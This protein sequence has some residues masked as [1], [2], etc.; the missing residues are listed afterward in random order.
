LN[1]LEE[2][3]LSTV[4]AIHPDEEDSPLPETETIEAQPEPQ[5]A[6][7]RMPRTRRT[8][9]EMQAITDPSKRQENEEWLDYLQRIP[10]GDWQDSRMSGLYVYKIGRQGFANM[11]LGPDGK[12]FRKPI[13]IDDLKALAAQHGPGQYKIQLSHR[14][15]HL[16][17]GGC[18]FPFDDV[19]GY[20]SKPN[21][22]QQQTD[23]QGINS[24]ITASSQ[25]LEHSAK[26]AID[27]QK[28]VHVENSKQPD[29]GAML[30]GVASLLVAMHPKQEPKEDRTAELIITMLTN[31]AKDA[32]RR[33]E[34]AEQQAI[35]QRRL[36]REDAERRERQL[37]EDADRRAERDS[38][39]W[40]V[41][42]K[43]KEKKSDEFG[44]TDLLKGIVVPLVKERIEGGGAPEGWAGVV[45]NL[46]EQ[47]P[48]AVAGVSALMAA[49]NGATPQQVA[50]LQ[51]PVPPPPQPEQIT[52]QMQFQELVRR[53]GLYCQRDS[54]KWNVDY[55]G[56]MV[57][58]E[59][60]GIAV[61]LFENTAA[62][63][64]VEYIKLTPPGDLI[65]AHPDGP[66][67]IGKLI[68]YFK[69]EEP[70]EEEEPE[71]IMADPK[72]ITGRN[73]K[74][75]GRAKAV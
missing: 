63:K 57:Q 53:I 72:T 58:E 55:L 16:S 11:P 36:D 46:I 26:T 50:A 1:A 54:E 65:L 39:F 71:I 45:G 34:R 15:P 21:G 56:E 8:K 14:L 44:L 47:V 13:T 60:G 31:Q 10:V 30:S 19:P 69:T 43:E 40:E 29:M 9:A 3:V 28:S 67:F 64:I 6:E 17:T 37:K 24:A 33:A 49:R 62:E 48:N 2:A 68:E 66:A 73:R 75:N 32:E 42:L 74:I 38:K 4:K 23:L 22:T 18:T 61:E 12:G 52:P 20:Q 7:P 41:M 59:Y 70:P 27:L 35:E 51:N 5:E 25:M